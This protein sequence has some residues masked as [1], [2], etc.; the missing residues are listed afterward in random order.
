MQMTNSQ[1]PVSAAKDEHLR[2]L[3]NCIR[4]LSMDAVQKANSDIKKTV[5]SVRNQIKKAFGGNK[6][7]DGSGNGDGGEG[8]AQ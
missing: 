8:G 2:K 1:V 3:A 6:D 5:T 4:F 7:S